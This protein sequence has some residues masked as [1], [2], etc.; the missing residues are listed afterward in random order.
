MAPKRKAAAAQAES[1][2]EK[3]LWDTLKSM[4]D[5]SGDPSQEILGL[6]GWLTKKR[7]MGSKQEPEVVEDVGETSWPISYHRMHQVGYDLI[8]YIMQYFGL[9]AMTAASMN[10]TDIRYVFYLFFGEPD[11]M[12]PKD[13]RNKKAQGKKWKDV[14]AVF[15]SLRPSEFT[16]MT[17]SD[18]GETVIDW[19][20]IPLQ[21]GP[22]GRLSVVY[23]SAVPIPGSSP[24]VM[25]PLR[26]FCLLLSPP[27]LP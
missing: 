15:A 10:P 14:A 21:K 11:S 4:V 25:A 27:S 26:P 5:D 24:M 13:L 7:K 12:L 8:V 20:K 22:D 23:K 19:S 6:I 3:E 18:D 1:Q 17:R 2:N 16:P 9:D